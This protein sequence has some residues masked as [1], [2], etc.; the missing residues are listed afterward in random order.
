MFVNEV[1]RH[2]LDDWHPFP[3]ADFFLPHPVRLVLG[4]VLVNM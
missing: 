2:G 1:T 4:S 3:D